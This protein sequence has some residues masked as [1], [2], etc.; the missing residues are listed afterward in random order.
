LDKPT[1]GSYAID[2]QDTATL[3]P[4]ELAALRRER[5]G[6]IF[7]RYHLLP[8][9]DARG[10]VETPAV[11]A[12]WDRAHRKERSLAL[13]KRLGLG[14]RTT[15]HPNQLSGGQQQRVSIARAL[16]NGGQIILAD[17]PTGAL[18]SASGAEMLKILEE[19][20][21][22]GHTVILVTHDSNVASHARRVIEI[23]DGQI[24]ADRINPGRERREDV[25]AAQP[26]RRPAGLLSFLDGP[27]EALR[28]ALLAMNAHKLRT[29][30]TMLGI[31][32]GIAS[33]VSIVAL[34]A[35][36]QKAIL[37][38]IATMG[39]NTITIY[40]GR[41]AGDVR[42]EGNRTLTAGDVA[43]LSSQDFLDSV[44]PAVDAR[45]VINRGNISAPIVINGVGEQY[46]RVRNVQLAEGRMFTREG[47]E[48]YAQEAVI[49]DNTARKMFGPNENPLG[50]V[51]I[52]GGVPYV[53]IGVTKAA[54]N[55]IF[56]AGKDLS[57]FAPYTTVT[58]RML[59]AA[60]LA[61]ITV[62]MKDGVEADVAEEAM[63]RLLGTRH[64][65]RDF[66]MI[67]AE[68]VRRTIETVTLMMSLL[69]GAIGGISLMVGGL[70]VMNIML[71]SV[72]ERT[73]EIGVRTAIGARR[74]DIMAQFVIEAVLVCL[75]GGAVGIGLSMLLGL[76]FDRFAG[77]FTMEFSAGSI[78]A[79][80]ITSTVIGLVFGWLPAR[81][82]ARLDP[83][84]ALARE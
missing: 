53:V 83:I 22:D 63:T 8:D 12:G 37:S 19:L 68:S 18:D 72:T 82:A 52:A 38:E 50:Q 46:F 31:V 48:S 16:M 14:E 54:D 44:T 21:A 2:G 66:Y 33:V 40:S 7:Q 60:Q 35:G 76:A 39:S 74:S 3:T 17:E 49:D 78:V 27:S 42:T 28:M 81:N 51:V 79:A 80:F 43:A 71:V 77:G 73:R 47:R 34:G 1:R 64:G 23:K 29:A 75:M 55:A 65:Q 11:Y 69:I 20:N 32:I 25:K 57:L 10:N 15:H 62:R 26:H 5:F 84:E 36:S 4:D 41:D 67:S 61:S 6:F 58:A 59:R 13:L 45:G 56:A 9:L 30:L 24:I 70:G